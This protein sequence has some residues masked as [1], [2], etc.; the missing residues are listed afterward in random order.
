MPHLCREALSLCRLSSAY[1][2]LTASRLPMGGGSWPAL[3]ERYRSRANYVWRIACAAQKL[4][5]ER[6]LLDEDAERYVELALQEGTCLDKADCTAHVQ[7]DNRCTA[8][9]CRATR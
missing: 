7:Y 1:T 6:L 5:K 9:P 2:F 4:V 3:A 8:S